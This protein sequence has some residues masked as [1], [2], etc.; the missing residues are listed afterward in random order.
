MGKYPSSKNSQNEQIRE[1]AQ[2]LKTAADMQ[3]KTGQRVDNL[4]AEMAKVPSFIQAAVDSISSAVRGES[5]SG[6]Q[7]GSGTGGAAPKA[8]DNQTVRPNHGGPAAISTPTFLGQR[9]LGL[10]AYQQHQQHGLAGLQRT[11]QSSIGN[12]IHNRH[13]ARSG[14]TFLPAAHDGAGNVTH[15]QRYNSS[16]VA[17][18]P[19]AEA[20]S[21]GPEL[22][23]AGTRAR[24]STVAA[25]MAGGGIVGA[26]KAVP[27][28]GDVIL[29]A[30]AVYG[31]A[32][33]VADQRARNAQFQNIYGGSNLAGMGQRFD[34]E[35]FKLGQLF[36]GGLTGAQS[37]QAFMGVSSLGL[38][39]AKR[40]QGLNFI[41]S[42]YK[43]QGTDVQTSLSLVNDATKGFGLTLDTLQTQLKQV[44][45]AAKTA[46]VNVGK[47]AQ[48][49][50]AGTSAAL[51]SGFGFNS[52]TLGKGLTNA[53]S[54][55]SNLY[56]GVNYNVMNN[57]TSIRIMANS[58]GVSSGQFV[59]QANTSS[60]ILGQ[61]T[62]NLQEQAFTA[63]IGG[64]MAA[65]QNMI[66]DNGGPQ[67]VGSSASA[68]Q[69]IATKLMA[70]NI[71]PNP[72][73]TIQMLNN[74]FGPGAFPNDPKQA[75]GQIVAWVA[76]KKMGGGGSLGNL[77][78][79]VTDN[80][81]SQA[82]TPM[83]ASSY[84][85]LVKSSQ[86]PM[87]SYSDY[88]KMN[89][90]SIESAI[91]TN[92]AIGA[93]GNPVKHW[94][95]IN[96]TVDPA[97]TSFANKEGNNANVT[98]TSKDGKQHTAKFSDALKNG[99]FVAAINSGEAVL[100]TGGRDKAGAKL[101]TL[102]ISSAIDTPGSSSDDTSTT[103]A[104][105]VVVTLN[106]PPDVRKALGL[107]VTTAPP[108]VN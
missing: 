67:A 45:A 87:P 66:N 106:V 7:S 26:A 37:D 1:I 11:V 6:G 14:D 43:S 81:P 95:L 19:A 97:L 74:Y 16:G 47:T 39:G 79:S 55:G 56:S 76:N 72:D 82:N 85:A 41:A 90:K 62:G 33:V 65:I 68:Q 24:I 83:T 80:A 63:A 34:Q 86:F 30:E 18:G 104:N 71:F 12:A 101:S 32:K 25:G 9:N 64:N 35:T 27:I 8:R 70:A 42:N 48:M 107:S 84:S 17:I 50:A 54:G 51:S 99:D 13:G 28:A 31:G 73:A 94:E 60:Q 78:G 103:T 22:A 4:A 69:G 93:T 89:A 15:Y 46:G 96:K 61:G 40:K 100:G 49:F 38:Q 3:Q 91:G 102:G 59:G 23:A 29:G 36:S 108:K 75:I 88:Q 77:S 5:I 21:L 57:P 52:G 53:G 58:L 2:L 44:T 105:G 98:I 92:D 20:G 10:S